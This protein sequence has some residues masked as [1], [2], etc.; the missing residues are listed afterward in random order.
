MAE[1]LSEIF[2]ELSES[3]EEDEA[4]EAE[5][6]SKIDDMKNASIDEWF[7]SQPIS[8]HFDIE[9]KYAKEFNTN[10]SQARKKLNVTVKKFEVEGNDIPTVVKQLKKYRRTLKGEAKLELSKSIDNLIKS[11]SEHLS[12][13]VDNIYWIKKYKSVL[14][15][16]VCSEENII[17]LSYVSE[18]STRREIIDT[19]CKY[20]E[21]KLHMR[22]MHI[23][24]I[25]LN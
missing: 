9:K 14:N 13:S 17:K 23:I 1:K 16:M 3:A 12:N 7:Y 8:S 4:L 22:D 20:W 18:E 15:D 11:Y 10:L 25:M 21:D 19:L 6:Q 5:E 24:Q 2:E